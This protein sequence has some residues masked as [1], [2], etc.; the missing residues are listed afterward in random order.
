M[1]LRISPALRTLRTRTR[2]SLLAA[3]RFVISGK[4]DYEAPGNLE[5][6]FYISLTF[7]GKGTLRIKDFSIVDTEEAFRYLEGY[8]DASPKDYK[9]LTD[10]H[11]TIVRQR[12]DRTTV[13]ARLKYVMF[14]LVPWRVWD[15]PLAIW[16]FLII[17]LFLGMFCLVTIFF[18]QW[19]QRDRMTFPLQT[20]ILDL[21]RTDGHGQLHILKQVPFWAGLL[22]CVLHLSLANAN[23]HVPGLPYINTHCVVAELLPAGA[24]RNSL[25]PGPYFPPIAVDVRPLY[26]AI[27]F[28]M[29]LEISLSLVVF[30]LVSCV[31]RVAGFFTPLKTLPA[32]GL[33]REYGFPFQRMLSA[34]GLLFLAVLCVFSARRHLVNVAGHVLLGRSTTN[35]ADEAISYRWAS[36][37]LLLTLAAF[38]SFAYLVELNPWF[39]MFFLSTYLLL[40]LSAARIRAESGLPHV[41]IMI[42]YPSWIYIGLGSGLALGFHEMTFTVQ[43]SFL[44]SGI[45][46]MSAPILA[47]AMAAATRIGVPLKKL[48]RCLMA[49]FLI[50]VVIGGLISMSWAYTVGTLGMNSSIAQKRWLYNKINT[51]LEVDEKVINHYF[52]DHP[53]TNVMSPDGVDELSGPNPVTLILVGTTFAITGLLALARV[54]WLG[55]PLHPLGFA[56]AF[57]PALNA[58]WSSIAVAY[59]VKYLALRFGGLQLVRHVLR[60]F[61]VGVFVGDLFSVVVWRAIDSLSYA[62]GG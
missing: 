2:P 21:T 62:G 35:D 33:Y 18:R 26:V 1:T 59:L 38:V 44:Y 55:F 17:G 15:R 13:L 22:L 4:I 50:A 41:G 7:S 34:G 47:E 3:D 48:G 25:D 23:Q 20:F 61:F 10:S 12:P 42:A 6:R 11:H 30:Y 27:A 28:F 52:R 57:T 31:Y 46:L 16:G 19:Q 39:V 43:V 49:G 5:D 36:A 37:G 60:P 9:A 56:L 29:S 51:I 58:L 45:F 54:I 14:G 32:A 53:E 40:S 24:L 8:E